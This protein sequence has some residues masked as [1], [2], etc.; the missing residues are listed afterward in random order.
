MNNNRTTAID[1]AACV[2]GSSYH[3][4]QGDCCVNPNWAQHCST[5]TERYDKSCQGSEKEFR[6]VVRC[7]RNA[8]VGDTRNIVARVSDAGP[9]SGCR[10]KQNHFI[11]A[12]SDLFFRILTMPQ[13]NVSS[14]STPATNLADWRNALRYSGL[15]IIRSTEQPC[16]R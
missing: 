16:S 6:P 10:E 12:G 8:R 7:V 15:Q 9:T 14:S 4:F 1:I 13:S 11:T 2:E 3:L 5:I